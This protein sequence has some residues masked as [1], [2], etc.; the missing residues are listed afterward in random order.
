MKN[1]LSS[2]RPFMLALAVIASATCLAQAEPDGVKVEPDHYRGIW[3]EAARRPMYLT[4][5]CVAGYS[6]YRPGPS[7]GIKRH[8][9]VV[10]GPNA[11]GIN[12]KRSG[13]WTSRF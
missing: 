7:N 10:I 13:L 11:I 12:N 8:I 1:H 3:L 9:D 6:T 5:G 2:V 4:Y